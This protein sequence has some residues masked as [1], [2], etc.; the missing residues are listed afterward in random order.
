MTDDRLCVACGQETA[1][2][3]LGGRCWAR[4]N[5]NLAGTVD[6][7]RWL[8]ECMPRGLVSQGEPLSG[9]KSPPI[10]LILAMH[11]Q[12][13][14]IAGVLA[15]WARM[16]AEDRSLTGPAGVDP[17][18]VG[19]WLAPHLRWCATQ[20]WVDDLLT[21]LADVVRQAHTTAPWRPHIH[22]LP[23]PC[24]DCGQVSL[25]IL[26]GS[27]WV[28]CRNRDCGR[29]LGRGFYEQLARQAIELHQQGEAA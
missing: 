14:H 10:P 6:A 2:D 16:V 26:G 25:A 23:L 9:T 15:S 7:W 24:P 11:D 12:R 27:D 21:E 1:R 29:L 19:A 8:G 4:L 3:M 17:P 28:T 5:R 22:R 18:T 20:P 13:V